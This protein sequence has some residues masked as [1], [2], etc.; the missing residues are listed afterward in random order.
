MEQ[1]KEKSDGRAAS[2]KNSSQSIHVS[3]KIRQAAREQK[4]LFG[5]GSCMLDSNPTLLL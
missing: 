4:A 3:T 5:M 1:R 2:E